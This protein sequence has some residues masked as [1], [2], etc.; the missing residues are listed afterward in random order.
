MTIDLTL[1]QFWQSAAPGE[2]RFDP[3][4]VVHLPLAIRQ[5]L[6]HAIAPGAPLAQAVRL[7]MHGHIKLN[8]NWLPFNAEQVIIWPR[9]FIWQAATRMAGLLPIR[10]SDRLIDGQGHMRW[11]MLGLIPVMTAEGPDISRSAAGRIAGEST[12][13]PSV[14]IRPEV[15]W[16][17]SEDDPG[18]LVAGYTIHDESFDVELRLADGGRLQSISYQRWGDPDGTGYRYLPFGGLVEEERTFG[19]YTIPGRIR[20]GWH[21]G[22]DRFAEEGEFFRCVIDAAEFR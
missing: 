10:G 5:Y 18:R 1:D 16:A 12:W 9:G 7:K 21:F 8:K 13:L 15:N 3:A 6:S 20:I 22:T 2:G 4:D 14:L 17:A 11:K 19:G